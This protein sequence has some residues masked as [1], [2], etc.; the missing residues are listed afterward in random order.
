MARTIFPH[1]PELLEMKSVESFSAIYIHR[2]PVD[3]RKSINGLSI[4][5]DQAMKLDLQSSSLFL[6][7]NRKRS[8]VKMLYFDRT[9]FALWLK[10]LDQS[11]FPWPKDFE[12][13]VVTVDHA[14]LIMMLEGINIF[15]RHK[16]VCFDQLF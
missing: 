3:M 8:H 6:F 5:V 7:S 4:I 13:D 15:S 16:T 12:E 11:K 9:G 2:D 1:L 10:K 14:N